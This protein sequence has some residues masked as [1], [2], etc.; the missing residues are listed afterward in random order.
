MKLDSG[1]EAALVGMLHA[2]PLFARMKKRHVKSILRSAQQ[3][4]FPAGELI[5]KEGEFGV[6]F[7]LIIEGK[8]AVSKKGK[9]LAKLGKGNFFGE[10]ALLDN[11]PR[12]ADVSAEENT[13]CLVLSAPTFWSLVSSDPKL[14][15]A[16]VQELAAR[17][18]ASNK[19]LSE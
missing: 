13:R 9:A 2:I 12:S 3:K 7:Y 18:R 16:L 4:S 19:A 14:A 1:E 11:Q 5:V 15:R 10:M 8:A 17:I 6:A